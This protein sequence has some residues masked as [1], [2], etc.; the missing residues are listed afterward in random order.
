M[1]FSDKCYSAVLENSWIE[2]QNVIS[3]LLY[4]Y[5]KVGAVISSA[6]STDFQLGLKT[7]VVWVA[8]LQEF[9]LDR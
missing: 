8:E 1:H 4:F 3:L 6:Q 2:Q 5:F 9:R 7:E